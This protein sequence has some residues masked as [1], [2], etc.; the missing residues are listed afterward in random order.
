MSTLLLRLA[1]PLQSWGSD[2]KFERRTTERTPTKSGVVGLIAAALGRK[3]HESIEDLLGLRFGVRV[4]REG[5]LLRDYHTVKLDKPYVTNRYYLVDAVFLAGIEGAEDELIKIDHALRNPAYPLYLGRR[6]CPPEGRVSLG[7]R[8]GKPL[9]DAL[10]EE[11]WLTDHPP[12]QFRLVCDATPEEPYNYMQR[13]LP[14]SFH[15]EQ[16]KH[17]YRRVVEK[18]YQESDILLKDHEFADNVTEHDPFTGLGG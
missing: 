4:D 13:D 12:H 5:K 7:I 2:S 8:S 1:G 3:R 9:L 6:S 15:Y 11:P 18:I 10:R 14:I 16:R 17:G